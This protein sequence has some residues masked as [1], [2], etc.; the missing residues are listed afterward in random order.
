MW[1][2]LLQSG[3]NKVFNCK[4][5]NCCSKRIISRIIPS[6]SF[7]YTLISGLFKMRNSLLKGY[8]RNKSVIYIR[9]CLRNLRQFCPSSWCQNFFIAV[10]FVILLFSFSEKK[11]KPIVMDLILYLLNSH[12]EA[13]ALN[14]TALED[15]NLKEK[16]KFNE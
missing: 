5:K 11:I 6:T 12:F 9:I 7:F 8:N 13:L 14:V 10:A 3:S 15:K 16:I 4:D 1:T 2:P